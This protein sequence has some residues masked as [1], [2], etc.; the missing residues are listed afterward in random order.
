[1]TDVVGDL[2]G[3]GENFF[4]VYILMSRTTRGHDSR[5]S[6]LW[7]LVRSY[8]DEYVADPQPPSTRKDDKTERHRLLGQFHLRNGTS[9]G[10]RRETSLSAMAV[11]SAISQI[12]S[13][14]RCMA[15]SVACFQERRSFAQSEREVGCSTG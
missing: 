13:R 8:N 15:C 12:P 2:G 5:G 9:S 3:F 1:M 14:P 11:S 7:R 6:A 4:A 10:S